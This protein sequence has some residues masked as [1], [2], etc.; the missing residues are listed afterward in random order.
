MTQEFHYITCCVNANGDD[1]NA[2]VDLAREVSYRTI[3]RR[4]ADLGEWAR[5]MGYCRGGL[6]LKNDWAVSYYKS[7]YRK[8][9]CYY[10]L[11]SAIE[12]IFTRQANEVVENDKEQTR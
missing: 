5:S 6:T 10:I 8:Q 1:I 3:R 2:M 9:P 12:Y 11:H 7:T 4:C